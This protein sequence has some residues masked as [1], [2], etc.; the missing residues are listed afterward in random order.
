MSHHTK[1]L[2]RGAILSTTAIVLGILS[3]YTAWNVWLS[4]KAIEES[5][6]QAATVLWQTFY[7]KKID[8]Q[9]AKLDF[10]VQHFGANPQA[11]IQHNSL[12]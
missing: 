11:I 12:Q 2:L 1:S 7:G 3:F 9:D 6:Q 10:I 8:D 5:N 4:Q